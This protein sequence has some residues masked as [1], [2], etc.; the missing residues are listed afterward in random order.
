[1]VIDEINTLIQ[2]ELWYDFSVKQ[3][4]DNQ[5]VVEGGLSLSYPDIEILFQGIFFTSFPFY[6]KTDAK[7]KV[8]TLVQGEEERLISEK[9]KVE[10][11]HFIFKFT[12]EDYPNEFGCLIVAKA[13]SYKIIKP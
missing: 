11:H 9:F 1:L 12:P 6:W 2:K 3:Y 5:L 8:L 13:I 10:Y 4:L 7:Q